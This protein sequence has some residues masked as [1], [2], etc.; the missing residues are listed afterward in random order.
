MAERSQ[1]VTLSNCPLDFVV[2]DMEH[3]SFDVSGLRDAFQYLLDRRLIH[4]SPTLATSVSPFVRIAANG[5]ELNQW[6]AKQVLDV[7]AYGIICPH[8]N[9]AAEA[10]NA[11]SACR[12]PRPAESAAYEPPG[13]RGDSPRA[14]ARYWGLDEL[15][16]YDH[17]D[18]WPL[19]QNGD[20][21]VIIMCE[22][23][24]AVKNL[25][26]ILAEVEGI[27]G[28]LIGDGDLSQD[29]GYPRQYDHP[30]VQAAVRE[31]LDACLAAGVPCGI[32]HVTPETVEARIDEGFS[33]L[34]SSAV[35]SRPAVERAR[36]HAAAQSSALGMSTRRTSSAP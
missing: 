34:L 9:N 7:G 19:V 5:A 35:P 6:Q 29:L 18:V 11:V 13:R 20:I 23:A 8:I 22:E 32:P 26:A 24:R 15:T 3:G 30:V 1:A 28:V 21:L 10:S 25:P 14:A 2:F 31:A 12:Y 17:A 33:F 36:A 27:G 4:E 16:Y